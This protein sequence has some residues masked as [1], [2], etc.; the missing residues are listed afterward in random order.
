MQYASESKDTEL[1]EEL[2]QWFLQEEK[3]ECFGA[4]LFTCYDLLRPDVCPSVRSLTAF[5]WQFIS[6]RGG[7]LPLEA[8][9]G[10]SPGYLHLGF[11]PL[12][13][14]QACGNLCNLGVGRD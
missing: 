3:R 5:C 13:P 8:H 11:P 14:G 9:L 1:A 6:G 7:L 2:L 10:L 12:P 4:C